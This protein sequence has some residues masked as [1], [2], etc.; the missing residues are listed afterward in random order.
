M[1]NKIG[2]YELFKKS[3]NYDKNATLDYKVII[4]EYQRKY[5]WV[6]EDINKF[7]DELNKILIAINNGSVSRYKGPYFGHIILKLNKE[8]KEIDIIDG[9]QR[10]TTFLL[11]SKIILEYLENNGIKIGENHKELNEFC[12]LCDK[13]TR[14]SHQEVNKSI[15]EQ[16]VFFNFESLE[17]EKFN[18]FLSGNYKEVNCV[19]E[20]KKTNSEIKRKMLE[21]YY[22]KT[23]KIKKDHYFNIVTN[24]NML[25]EFVKNIEP[26]ERDINE[27][28]N[29]LKLFKVSYITAE[30]LDEAFDIFTSINSTGRPLTDFDLIK[31]NVLSKLKENKIETNIWNK[32][33]E[34]K[35]ICS[36][37]ELAEI[38]DTMV[39]VESG[40]P[41]DTKMDKI[42]KRVNNYVDKGDIVEV[43]NLMENYLNI[44]K[45]CYIGKFNLC[46]DKQTTQELCKDYNEDVQLLFKSN[47]KA[48]KPYI[49]YL[50]RKLDETKENI[51]DTVKLATWLPLTYVSIL[52]NRPETLT[53]FIKYMNDK[54]VKKITIAKVMEEHFEHHLKDNTEI[55][56]RAKLG[57]TFDQKTSKYLLRLMDIKCHSGNSVETQLEHMF[58]QKPEQDVKSEY[59]EY[60]QTI[61]EEYEE[62][63]DDGYKE[64]INKLGNLLILSQKVNKKS[65]N[66]HPNKKFKFY[67]QDIEKFSVVEDFLSQYRDKFEISDV[68]CRTEKIIDEFVSKAKDTGIID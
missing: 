33:I 14:F 21:E 38:F 47:Y 46:Y 66:K 2:I 8:N 11:L 50:L 13:N 20:L 51:D 29:M 7:I 32:Q 16:Y 35:Q 53:N 44:Y 55:R 26:T 36:D 62:F 42:Y 37:K 65:K 18:K 31:S 19:E 22:K 40:H 10:M 60:I 25:E 52:D 39:L 61:D 6:K 64:F 9:Q 30:D 57:E 17:I 15:I 1:N 43:I 45:N 28:I 58:S 68:N 49:Y 24:F 54:N 67:E 4:P 56:L 5:S 34:G 41:V 12:Y 3:V 23:K 27:F 63:D 48:T 59:M